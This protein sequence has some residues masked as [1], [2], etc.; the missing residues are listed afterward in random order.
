M[1]FERREPTS[2][3]IP[4][5]SQAPSA[6]ARSADPSV[7]FPERPETAGAPPESS[8]AEPEGPSRS[9]LGRAPSHIGL[10]RLD[11]P[12]IPV[13]AGGRRDQAAAVNPGSPRP[14]LPPAR[15]E[16]RRPLPTESN[17]Q[18]GE[19][20][21]RESTVEVNIAIGHIEVRSVPRPEVPRRPIA[22]PRVTLDEYLRR[23]NGD[24]R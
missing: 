19:N 20:A 8:A 16:P 6:G 22:R 12:P 9:G 5:P 1:P 13:R 21:F 18:G 24:S 2:H 10:A 7:A 23:R 17:A 14:D 15:P 3:S 4:E 11:P